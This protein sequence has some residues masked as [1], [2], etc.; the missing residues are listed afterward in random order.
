MPNGTI[1]GLDAS[2]LAYY[3]ASQLT[4]I[5][6]WKIF[7]SAITISKIRTLRNGTIVGIRRSDGSLVQRWVWAMACSS[8]LG[9]EP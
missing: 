4:S 1:L 2:G 5:D 8:G 7:P 9:M 6:A 3:Y